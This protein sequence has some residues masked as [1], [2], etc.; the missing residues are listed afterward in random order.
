MSDL[1]T[2][3]RSYAVKYAN[4]YGYCVA[5]DLNKAAA[6]I[7]ALEAALHAAFMAMCAHRD[8]PDDEVFQ[9]AI[10]ALGMAG[11]TPERK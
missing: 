7:E 8:S 1:A 10:Y 11:L 4:D 2:N 9:D 5:S 6:R 3:L